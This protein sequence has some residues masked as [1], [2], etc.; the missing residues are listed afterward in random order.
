MAILVK[1]GLAMRLT[2]IKKRLAQAAVVAAWAA[3]AGCQRLPYIDQSKAV[4]HE[5]LG[6]LKDEDKEVKQAEFLSSSMALPMPIPA[7]K[8]AR[9]MENA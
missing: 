6:T 8:Q 2:R 9:M 7:R 1:D 5:N 3:S 4:P